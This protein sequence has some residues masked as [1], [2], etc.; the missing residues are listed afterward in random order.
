MILN[1]ISDNM[2]QGGDI[3]ENGFGYTGSYTLA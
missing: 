1:S 2:I 3:S